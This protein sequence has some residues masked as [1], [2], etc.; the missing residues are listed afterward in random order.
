MSGE[1]RAEDLEFQS[2]ERRP[3]SAMRRS[4][5]DQQSDID[6]ET[7]LFLWWIQMGSVGRSTG[8][9]PGNSIPQQRGD[10]DLEKQ[11]GDRVTH[12]RSPGNHCSV[13]RSEPV[14]SGNMGVKYSQGW[15]LAATQR[16]G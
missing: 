5:W 4:P 15:E 2:Q 16:K 13:L 8:S 7:G 6:A 1:T 11:S 12:K 14:T 10:T 3:H 9:Q